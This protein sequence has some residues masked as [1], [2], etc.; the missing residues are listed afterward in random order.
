MQPTPQLR[1]LIQEPHP[2]F[3]F[4]VTQKAAP[5]GLKFYATRFGRTARFIVP[6]FTVFF[7]WTFAT[8]YAIDI[9]NGVR[10]F[11]L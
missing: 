5:V 4:P 3:R 9:K 10:E 8:Q 11:P 6:A 7:G 2:F 1:K